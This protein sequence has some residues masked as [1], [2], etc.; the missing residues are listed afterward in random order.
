MYPAPG[1]RSSAA[2]LLAKRRLLV[3]RQT[4]LRRVSL[5]DMRARIA[6]QIAGAVWL[7]AQTPALAA[8]GWVCAFEVS[9]KSTDLHK[10]S[11]EGADLVERSKTM[12]RYTC[13][14]KSLACFGK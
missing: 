1:T 14:N 8:S 4:R 6:H 7:I 10:F 5:A 9:G 11:L 3:V 13:F 12:G 2:G